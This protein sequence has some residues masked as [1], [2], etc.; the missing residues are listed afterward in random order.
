MLDIAVLA[1]TAVSSILLPYIKDGAT[2]FIK[3]VTEKSGE[4]MGEYAADLAGK[5]WDKVKSVFSS[6]ADQFVVKEFEANPEA[7]APLVEAKLK[8]KLEQDAELAKEMD[9]LVN[10]KTPDGQSTGAQ[11]IGSSYVGFIDLRNSHISGSGQTFTGGT[12][13]FG[14]G[15]ETK[16]SGIAPPSRTN[17]A[18]PT[19]RDDSAD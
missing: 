2:T 5:V 8:Q 10:A 6:E 12:F 3:T 4:G 19:K 17:V 16:A 15:A 14:S 11:I 13:N 9:K 7:A 18:E 1:T